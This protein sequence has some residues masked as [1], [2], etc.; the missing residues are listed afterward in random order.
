[1]FREI[2]FGIFV[3]E[4][5]GKALLKLVEIKTKEMGIGVLHIH[6]ESDNLGAIGLYKT[7][8]FIVERV[9]LRKEVM[10]R[11]SPN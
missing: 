11:V 4:G 5:Y 10:S 7:A 2:V 6:A 1:M 8:G 9:Q 3:N